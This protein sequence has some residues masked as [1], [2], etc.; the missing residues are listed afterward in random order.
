MSKPPSCQNFISTILTQSSPNTLSLLSMIRLNDELASQLLGDDRNGTCPATAMESH[1]I[2][3]R[4]QLWPLYQKE[5]GLQV[6]S[7]KKLADN[8][9]SSGMAGLLGG[10]S[11]GIKDSA[12]Q[13]VTRK[14]ADLF[15]GVVALSKEDDDMVFNS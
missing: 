6:D 14:Y 15:A 4:L 3:I 11:A 1:I 2:G 13:T 12:V 8:S 7:V 10:R 9:G 5:M